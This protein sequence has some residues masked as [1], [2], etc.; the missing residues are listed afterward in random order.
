MV[1]WEPALLPEQDVAELGE[2]EFFGYGVDAGPGAFPP[3]VLPE[4]PVPGLLAS[5]VAAAGRADL[6]SVTSGWG[7]G[8][9]GT[10]IGWTAAGN[11]AAAVTDFGVWPAHA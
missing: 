7:D 10:W 4:E 2:D 6:V 8:C 3:G 9:L 5:G 11:V 1:A